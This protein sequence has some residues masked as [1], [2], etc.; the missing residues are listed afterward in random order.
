MVYIVIIFSLLSCLWANGIV[1]IDGS[2][3]M[4][5]FFRTKSIYQI[6]EKVV[7]SISEP[8]E[9]FVFVST[10]KDVVDFIAP[11]NFKLKKLGGYTRLKKALEK[12]LEKNPDFIVIITDNIPTGEEDLD[13]IEL[14]AE[15]M[16]KAIWALPVVTEFNG[17]IYLPTS[18]S[19]ILYSS[20]GNL[21][22]LGKTK[23]SKI[24][25]YHG[26]RGLL[27]YI[28]AISEKFY[29]K[30]YGKDGADR[31]REALLKQGI[32][33]VL[34]VKPIDYRAIVIR[35]E[36]SEMKIKSAIDSL[37]NTC[38][39]INIP[40]LPPGGKLSCVRQNKLMIL[41]L[42]PDKLLFHVPARLKGIL[43]IYFSIGTKMPYVVISGSNPCSL[44]V[45]ISVDSLK[46]TLNK[47]I[48]SNRKLVELLN[49]AVE[50]PEL[51]GQLAMPSEDSIGWNRF[52]YRLSILKSPIPIPWN[53]IKL[54]KVLF[55]G[56]LRIGIGF[57]IN[58][59]IPPE[60]LHTAEQ[61]R[62]KWFSDDIGELD[63]IYCPKDLINY[64]CRDTIVVSYNIGM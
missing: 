11:E 20:I 62:K 31:L 4:D 61:I 16:V 48:Y 56:P 50:P 64:F 39:F 9:I 52:V 13:F 57:K 49:I 33:D 1:L 41:P 10:K 42:G 51:I 12:A 22:L 63:K 19:D 27:I 26:K 32:K 55:S 15:P 14:L 24:Y 25:H 2:G 34:L 17:K 18:N 23:L 30:S 40:Y 47:S 44:G 6:S 35:P 28:L 5:G 3:S 54:L 53:P 60:V 43:A 59:I 8:A 21:R 36:I 38:P 46:I 45:K 29:N 7:R 37:K 58:I